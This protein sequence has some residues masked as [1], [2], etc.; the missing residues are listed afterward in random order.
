VSTPVHI[1]NGAGRRL[2]FLE[3]AQIALEEACGIRGV[4]PDVQFEKPSDNRGIVAVIIDGEK[5]LYAAG[6][7]RGDAMFRLASLIRRPAGRGW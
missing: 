1:G 5:R 6:E 2:S 4:T 3:R 7:D